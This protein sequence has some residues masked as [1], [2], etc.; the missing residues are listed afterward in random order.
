LKIKKS[1]RNNLRQLF[2]FIGAAVFI[3]WGSYIYLLGQLYLFFG[4]AIFI[5]WG[6]YIYFLGQTRG[7]APTNYGWNN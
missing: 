4:A 3:F 2:L 5:Y 1:C 6:S 7:S